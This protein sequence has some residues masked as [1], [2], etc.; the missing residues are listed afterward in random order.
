MSEAILFQRVTVVPG[1]GTPVREADVEWRGGRWHF[2]VAGEAVGEGVRVVAGE[3][4]VLLPGLF[5]LEAHLREPGREDAETVA[6][7]TA[8]AVNG[9]LR[10]C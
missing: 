10:D 1:D 4:K 3:G 7:G 6:S 5:D 8:A 2:P 9:G